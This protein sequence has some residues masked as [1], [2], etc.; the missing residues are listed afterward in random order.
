MSPKIDEALSFVIV[1]SELLLSFS[2]VDVIDAV[3]S[4]I[5]TPLVF[6]VF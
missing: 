1:P 6:S 4:I 5:L 2:T 3:S